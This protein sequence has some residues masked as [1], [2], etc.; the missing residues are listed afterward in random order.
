MT[1]FF[2]ILANF[3]ESH[4]ALIIA[5]LWIFNIGFLVYAAFYKVKWDDDKRVI[6][7]FL[8]ALL[9]F[10]VTGMYIGIAER[11]PTSESSV[12]PFSSFAQPLHKQELRTRHTVTSSR[13]Y[14][15]KSLSL[16]Q[17]QC[18]FLKAAGGCYD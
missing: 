13:M 7:A 18:S 16:L 6:A 1:N 2:E 10:Y 9:N 14:R 5:S 11:Q 12:R 8:L 4:L 3:F 15:W 17:F